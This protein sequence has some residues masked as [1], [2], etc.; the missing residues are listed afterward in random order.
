MNVEMWP[1]NRPVPYARNPRNNEGKAVAK[2]KSSIQEFGFKQPIVVDRQGVVVVGHT[3]LKA[4]IELGMPTVPVVIATD[5]TSAQVKAYRLADNRVAEESSWAADLLTL[6]LDDLKLAEFDL[7][8]TGFDPE[9]LHQFAP[10]GTQD[11]LTEDDACPELPVDPKSVVGDVWLLGNHRLMC[12]DSTNV[13]NVDELLAGTKADIVYTDPPYGI[14]VQMNNPGTTCKGTILG[15][16][17]TDV[18]TAAYNLCATFDVPMIFWGANHYVSDAGLPN[19][20]CWLCWDKQESNNHID[21]ADCEFAWTNIKGPAR[22]FHHLWAGFRRDSEKGETRVHP[23]QKPIAL[24][25]EIL[26]FFK[27]GSIVLDLFGGSGSTLIACEK[28]GRSCRMM[29]L[30]PKY[31]D[32]ILKR[33]QHFTGRQAVHADGTFFDRR[34]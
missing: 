4:A 30:D 34:D 20:S 29:E 22:V 32:V 24:N 19:A 21:Q 2:V 13:A 23:T 12:G 15:D 31:S 3:R 25:I 18:A 9:E 17:T 26:E 27:A 11:G 33:W 1:T 14:S 8:L 7:A 5:L 6:E 16:T 10:D 28:T